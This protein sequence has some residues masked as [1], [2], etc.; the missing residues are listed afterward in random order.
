MEFGT[1]LKTLRKHRHLTQEELASKTGITRSC[2]NNYENDIREPDFETAT[3]IADFF[4]VSM[5]TMIG[6]DFKPKTLIEDTAFF[7]E[8]IEELKEEIIHLK[9]KLYDYYITG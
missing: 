7:Q 1:R 6:R 5:D 9:A 2:I 8:Q 3:K 4:N